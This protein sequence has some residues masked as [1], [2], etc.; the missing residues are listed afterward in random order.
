VT[1]DADGPGKPTT[2]EPLTERRAEAVTGIRQHAAEAHTRTVVKLIGSTHDL[3]VSQGYRL[4]EDAWIEHGRRTY[5][6][7]DDVARSHI[8]S[9][10]IVLK[11]AGW[12]SDSEKLWSFVHRDCDEIIIEPGGP[13]TS[14]HFL[15]HM[16]SPN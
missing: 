16:K 3:L 5:I 11:S 12:K 14:G 10:S 15:H 4:T 2:R 9:L 13:D 1:R 7:D 8:I 6:H